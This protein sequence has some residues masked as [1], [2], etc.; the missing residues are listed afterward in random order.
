M[1]CAHT[2]TLKNGNVVP[3]GKCPSCLANERTEWIFRLKQEYKASSFSLFVTL[4]Y[5][6]E[7]LPFGYNVNKRDVQLF[8]KRFRKQL[9]KIKLRYYIVSEYGDHTF[10]PHYHGLF[11]F[12]S[13]FDDKRKLYD[14]IIDSW[15]N[16]FCSFGDVEEGSIVYCTK[17]CLKRSQ[18]P[19]GREKPFRLVSKM[20]G[21]LGYY[22]IDSLGSWHVDSQNYITVFDGGSR[23]RMPRYYKTLLQKANP[24]YL[25][26]RERDKE[27]FYNNALVDS[28]KAFA[29]FIKNHHFPNL[30]AAIDAYNASLER[31][32]MNREELIIKHTKKQRL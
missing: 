8:L 29:D 16:G 14:I 32:N 27:E 18:L 12:D 28:Q 19:S 3:C 31:R 22:Y 2:I 10:R 11:F 7:H 26:V 6:D 13:L 21:G 17:Y 25:R 30:Q 1:Q 5:D 15:Q 23:S 9:G 4:T 20:N 24:D